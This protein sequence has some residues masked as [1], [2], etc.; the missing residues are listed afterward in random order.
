MGKRR[1]KGQGVISRTT[2]TADVVVN[3][4]DVCP[5][6][7][8][9]NR[10]VRRTVWALVEWLSEEERRKREEKE[11]KDD[12]GDDQDEQRA[13]FCRELT[14]AS[15]LGSIP[16]SFG[17]ARQTRK[18]PGGAQPVA[19]SYQD[20][21]VFQSGVMEI[22]HE[23]NVMLVKCE[24]D[25]QWYPGR[26]I[27]QSSAGPASSVVRFLGWDGEEV[28]VPR[29]LEW[30]RPV[31]KN[32]RALTQTLLQADERKRYDLDPCPP[33]VHA[34]YWD[35]RLRLFSRYHRGI[36]MDE[37][38]WFSLTPECVADHIS[39]RC[40]AA[41]SRS[42]QHPRKQVLTIM[43]GFCGCGGNTVSLA[44]HFPRA[45]VWAV[46]C[47]SAKLDLVR[48]NARVYGVGGNVEVIAADVYDVLSCT[49]ATQ[50]A[51]TSHTDSS[52][53]KPT[54]DLLTMSPPWGGPAYLQQE[55]YY[56][57]S[58]LPSGDCAALARAAWAVAEVVVLLLPRNSDPAQL[59]AIAMEAEAAGIG[60]RTERI[61]LHGKHKVTALYLGSRF[62]RC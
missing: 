31:S 38:S 47:I 46:D 56:D 23:G 27:G 36:V 17:S 14:E 8:E 19:R 54:F 9:M 11:D 2:E 40:A 5:S 28:V 12:D 32:K 13:A 4:E 22:M 10:E 16:L 41:F 58:L 45:T 61:C 53:G 59:A 60:A 37:E 35:H 26:V 3:I 52:H 30:M 20:N 33:K 18:R 1:K 49:A 48:T 57:L 24:E 39:L 34:K 29:S 42:H 7:K 62:V 50:Q 15:L 21:A 55:P 44:R 43:D 25:G 51:S 6:V